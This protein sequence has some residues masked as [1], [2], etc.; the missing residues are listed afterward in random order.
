MMSHRDCLVT[1]RARDGCHV[2]EQYESGGDI[3]EFT[4][5]PRLL[6]AEILLTSYHRQQQFKNILT[7]V[8]FPISP[9]L[10]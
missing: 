9:L 2:C 10:K 7:R 5:L 8:R 6:N 3:A 4:V 1:G